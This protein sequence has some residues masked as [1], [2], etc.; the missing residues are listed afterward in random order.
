MGIFEGILLKGALKSL[1]LLNVGIHG[2]HRIV[3]CQ[4][5]DCAG[6]FASKKFPLNMRRKYQHIYKLI[7]SRAIHSILT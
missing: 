1:L 6:K 4:N 5:C 3:N 7:N 2:E